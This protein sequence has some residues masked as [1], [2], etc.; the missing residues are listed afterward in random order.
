[1]VYVVQRGRSKKIEMYCEKCIP[2][3]ESDTVNDSEN[4]LTLEPGNVL[5]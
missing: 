5:Q 1:M 3:E 4:V 2:V